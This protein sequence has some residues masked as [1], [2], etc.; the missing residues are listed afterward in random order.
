MSET[1]TTH[2]PET[3]EIPEP[4]TT[5]AP[6]ATEVPETETTQTPETEKTLSRVGFFKYCRIVSK[7]IASD[8]FFWNSIRFLRDCLRD[9]RYW[10]LIATICGT[11]AGGLVFYGGSPASSI[12]LF[13]S[14]YISPV[15]SI[16]FD[17]SYFLT[18]CLYGFLFVVPF[19]RGASRK[20]LGLMI[21]RLIMIAIAILAIYVPYMFDWDENLHGN[22]HF[23]LPAALIIIFYYTVGY[24]RI[25]RYLRS[26]R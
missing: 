16:H 6:E 4:E 11:L 25:I 14:V 2:A 10:W 22:F 18:G 26:K 5:Q 13:E 9:A 24:I 19:I 17:F 8:Y 1:E 23:L 20:R 15:A 3:T 12:E 21:K 7:D